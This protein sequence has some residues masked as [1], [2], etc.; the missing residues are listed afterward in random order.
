MINITQLCPNN[1]INT[2]VQKTG[3]ES[4]NS[5]VYN[6]NQQ[7]LTI[8]QDPY[9]PINSSPELYDSTDG[10]SFNAHLIDSLDMNELESPFTKELNEIKELRF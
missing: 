1:N 3:N 10:N 6:S 5:L 8:I 7:Y 9:P 2:V 4:N